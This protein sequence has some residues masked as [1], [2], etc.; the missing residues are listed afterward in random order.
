MV[1]VG[2]ITIPPGEVVRFRVGGGRM[3][4][5]A[6]T[7]DGVLDGTGDWMGKGCGAV[8]QISH[9]ERRK[10]RQVTAIV[11]LMRRL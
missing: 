11:F 8:P 4:G 7:I 5:V 3:M 10:A 9:A 6:V 1:D 2:V